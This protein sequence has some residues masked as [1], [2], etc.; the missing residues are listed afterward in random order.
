MEIYPAFDDVNI[1]DVYRDLNSAIYML[2]HIEDE[3]F[4]K[5]E[6]QNVCFAIKIALNTLDKKIE[7]NSKGSKK[8]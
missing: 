8:N 6:I 2:H 5:R 7:S 1:Q 3:V 4:S